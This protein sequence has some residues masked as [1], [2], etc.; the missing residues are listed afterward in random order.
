MMKEDPRVELLLH[1]V[2]RTAFNRFA[3]G[4]HAAVVASDG[5]ELVLYENGVFPSRYPQTVEGVRA[6]LKEADSWT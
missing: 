3:D 2:G 4:E 5:N 1:L 6:L